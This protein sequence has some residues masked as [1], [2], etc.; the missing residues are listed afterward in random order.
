[1]VHPYQKNLVIQPVGE[2][3]PAL[4]EGSHLLCG[5]SE[6]VSRKYGDV[7]TERHAQQGAVGLFSRGRE[8]RYSGIWG[9]G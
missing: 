7:G 1:M 4:G 5:V 9:Q 2:L 6:R 3:A 8:S